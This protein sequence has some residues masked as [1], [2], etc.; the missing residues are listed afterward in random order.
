MPLVV[1]AGG[2]VRLWRDERRLVWVLAPA[3]VLFVL[4]MGTQ[5]RFFGRWLMPVFPI[6]CLLAAYAA[7]ELADCGARAPAGAAADA[8]RR[9]PSSR[10]ARRASSTRCT[11]GRCCRATTRAT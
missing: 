8:H 2:A 10:C 4:F 7:L 3:A 11:S 1:A 6:V 9:R 5:E